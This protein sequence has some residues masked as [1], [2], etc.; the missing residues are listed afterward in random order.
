MAGRSETQLFQG[1][2]A[3]QRKAIAEGEPHIAMGGDLL[4]EEKFIP[5]HV[6][7]DVT[8]DMDIMNEEIFGPVLPVLTYTEL[9][10]VPP[11]I[12]RLERPL[13]LYIYSH[14]R[15]ATAFLLKNTTAGTTAINELMTTTSNPMV[16][17]GGVNHSGIG[18]S[19]GR[20]TFLEFS[21]ERGI[22]KRTWG[23]LAPLKPPF[24]PFFIKWAIRL[25]RL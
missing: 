2:R 6:L 20:H 17:F 23:T 1:S 15:K 14:D 8:P 11:L 19:G 3:L 12:A 22:Q 13:S 18:K 10:D 5:P 4:D 9:K 21:N 24:R 25:S 7:I 16:P